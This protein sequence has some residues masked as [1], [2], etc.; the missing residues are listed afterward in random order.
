M[1]VRLT[2]VERYEQEL[3]VVRQT[4]ITRIGHHCCHITAGV[5]V[6]VDQ[7]VAQE[8]GFGVLLSDANT[9]IIDT[10]EEHS[11]LEFDRLFLLLDVVQNAVHLLIRVRNEVVRGKETT[12]RNEQNHH[13]QRF[14]NLC[15]RHTCRFHRQQFVVLAQVTH[16]HNRSKE[17]RQWQTHRDHCG[18]SVE[19][20]LDNDGAVD[21][22]TN[23]IVDMLPDEVHHQHEHNDQEGEHHWSQ[24]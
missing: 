7:H 19:H 24:I 18:H 5:A 1:F 9:Q 21:T 11:V 14:E 17:R 12:Q 6:V 4:D 23:Q 8:L 3:L 13:K 2:V 15:Q 10:I 22:L 16:C 20:Q